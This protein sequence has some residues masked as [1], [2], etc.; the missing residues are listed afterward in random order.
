MRLSREEFNG[1]TKK[2]IYPYT[3]LNI[4]ILNITSMKLKHNLYKV[5]TSLSI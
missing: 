1:E 3:I 2:K 4:L 5:L